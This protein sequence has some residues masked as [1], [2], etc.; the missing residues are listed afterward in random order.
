M[1]KKTTE[2]GKGLPL[3]R[4][5]VARKT[6]KDGLSV[7]NEPKDGKPGNT[8]LD[9]AWMLAH[10]SELTPIDAD[11]EEVPF[12][13]GQRWNGVAPSLAGEF[14]VGDDEDKPC[15]GRA[16]VRDFT[17]RKILDANGV[18]LT[19]PCAK[20]PIKGGVS[21]ASHGGLTPQSLAAAKAR[22]LGAADAVVARLISIA[23][24]R[25]TLDA[26]AI[27]AINSILD[28]AGI[29]AGTEID[30]KTPEWQ[31]MLK[32]MFEKEGR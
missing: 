29:R 13:A 18:L 4:T 26:D 10:A 23:L 8:K 5:A 27:K 12:G 22:L 7:V 9:Q 17:G 31:D 32:E 21:C 15:T 25:E 1:A 28:R 6:R 11:E 14:M 30:L 3:G 19:R 2:T 24:G 20:R 16:Y